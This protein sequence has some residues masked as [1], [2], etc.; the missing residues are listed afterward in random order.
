[1]H[2]LVGEPKDYLRSLD[3]P[4]LVL[5]ERLIAVEFWVFVKCDF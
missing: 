1:M 5:P 4:N 2:K 3:Y